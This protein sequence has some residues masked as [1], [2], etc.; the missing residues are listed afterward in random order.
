ME[1]RK[2]TYRLYPSKSQG[3]A[4]SAVLR[5]HQQ[6]Y[7]AALEQRIDAWRRRGVSLSYQDQCKELTALRTECPEFSAINCSSQ[8]RTLRRLDIAFRAFFRRVKERGDRAGFPR[9]KSLDGFPGYGFKSH[10][11]GWRFTS[12]TDWKHG[13][14]RLQGIGTLKV[15]GQARQGGTG[16]GNGICR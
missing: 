1:R 12:G 15:R 10:G 4:L 5:S 13:R 2:I 16:T 14:L 6:L 8:Q 9:F 7:N 11:D 3:A